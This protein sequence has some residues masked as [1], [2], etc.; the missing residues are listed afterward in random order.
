MSPEAPQFNNRHRRAA[1]LFWPAIAAWAIASVVF[2]VVVLWQQPALWVAVSGTMACLP[3]VLAG[4]AVADLI[5]LTSGQA[6]L[7]V[8]DPGRGSRLA[9]W[10]GL[11][12]AALVLGLAFGRFVWG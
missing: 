5:R 4:F 10:Q 3:A 12:L 11:A 8:G 9:A 2:F 7:D 6:D 1:D